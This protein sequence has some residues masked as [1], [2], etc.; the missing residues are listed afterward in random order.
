MDRKIII[1]LFSLAIGIIL[2]FILIVP[3]YS[4]VRGLFAEIS[5]QEE[6]ITKLE[7]LLAKTKELKDGYQQVEAE[8]NRIFLGLPEEKDV[9]NLLVQFESL[10]NSNGLFLGAIKFGQLKGEE[11]SSP[12]PASAEE[13][14]EEESADQPAPVINQQIPKESSVDL[15]LSGSY[16][17]FKK[18]LTDI[19]KNIRS[20]DVS[21]FNFSIKE[22]GL[23]E[24]TTILTPSPDIFEFSL[25]INVY[26]Q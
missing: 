22:A 2:I 15:S 21:S 3:L 14:S 19:E 25:G 13:F 11:K 6:T 1:S 18:Y 9:P 7:E 5:Q 17:A 20:M 24:T 26:Y 10:A 12:A 23:G 16:S 8:A 4:S